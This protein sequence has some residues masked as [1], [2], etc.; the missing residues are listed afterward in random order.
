MTLL[1]SGCADEE[2]FDLGAAEAADGFLEKPFTPDEL[3]AAIERA[4]ARRRG[5]AGRV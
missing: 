3:A 4:A 5:G 2:V 1:V